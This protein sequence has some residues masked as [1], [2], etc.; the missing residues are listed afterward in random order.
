[1]LV[2][3]ISMYWWRWDIILIKRRIIKYKL[4]SGLVWGE[5]RI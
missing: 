3:L 2:I 4:N 1:M 5:N